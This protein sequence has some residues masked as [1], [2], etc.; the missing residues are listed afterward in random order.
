MELRILH[1]VEEMAAVERLQGVIWGGG[2][3][4]V[5]PSHLL[6]TFAHN[7]GLVAG[8]FAGDELAGFVYGF[9]GLDTSADSPRLKHC[10]HQ[11]GVHP[12]YRSAGI[13]FALKRLQWEFVAGQGIERITWTYDPLLAHNAQLNIAKLGAVCS[14]YIRDLYGEMLDGLNAG[15]PSDRFQVDLWVKSPR[16]TA[17]M[18]GAA[19]PRP[20]VADLLAAG[21]VF[22][23]PASPAGH[24]VP[25]GP[26]WRTA[27]TP[28]TW[29]LEIPADFQALKVADRA[30]AS[31]WRQ[32][33]AAAFETLFSVGYIVSDFAYEPGA[34]P[35]AVYVLSK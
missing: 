6:V 15:L 18:T 29:L 24:P 32:G 14:T 10:S 4:E 5:V 16:V 13:G 11:L 1:T 25:P 21:A 30:R 34:S 28:D 8:A 26:A 19:G 3:L 27:A 33:T 31:A 22:V 2:D 35:W 23:N 12:N 9:P 7:G 17:C 20:T